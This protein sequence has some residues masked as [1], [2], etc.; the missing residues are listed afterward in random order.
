MEGIIIKSISNDWTVFANNTSFICKARG[1]FRNNN[2]S[3]MVG[4]NVI[5]NELE[6]IIIDIKPRKTILKRPPVANVDQA[7]IVTSVKSPDFS[8]NLLDKLLTII[9]YNNIKPIICWTKLDLL[10]DNEK[11]EMQ[12][13]ISYYENVGYQSITNENP[14]T[15]KKIFENNLTV[16]TG[17]SGAGKSTLINLLNEDLNLKTNDISKALG[18]GKHTTRHVELYNIYGGFIV[19]TPGFSSLDLNGLSPIAIRDNMIDMY[20]NL[21][22]CKYRDCMHLNEDGCAVKNL[23]L[24]SEILPSRYEN[25]KK[26][27][28]RS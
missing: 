24:T 21:P 8:A 5:F 25:Y 19:D 7:L 17:Q 13:Y 20:N 28:N 15:L 23:V 6:K 16:F 14:Q 3:P 11:I 22:N 2:I 10:N 27:I 4:D 9:S 1:K 18:R 12:K 26:F